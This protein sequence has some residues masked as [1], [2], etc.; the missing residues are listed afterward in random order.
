MLCRRSRT[1]KVQNENLPNRLC[2]VSE[3]RVFFTSFLNNTGD[4]K[5]VSQSHFLGP[6]RNCNLMSWSPGCE[7]GW[8]STVN[9]GQNMPLGFT[10]S[11]CKAKSNNVDAA[12]LESSQNGV[13]V[14]GMLFLNA[15]LCVMWSGCTADCGWITGHNYVTYRLLLNGVTVILYEGLPQRWREMET[16]TARRRV[17][18]L[19]HPLDIEVCPTDGVIQSEFKDTNT[20][21]ISDGGRFISGFGA[22]VIEALLI[23]VE[24]FAFEKKKNKVKGQRLVFNSMDITEVSI[25][26]RL[27]IVLLAI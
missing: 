24:W 14:G 5:S 2:T 12:L 23:G 22:G 19:C 26:H 20:G 4:K 9:P 27:G 7:A 17:G 8:A 11:G 1:C 13:S 3:L 21:K 15:V 6:T 16:E 10:L 25:I 18:T